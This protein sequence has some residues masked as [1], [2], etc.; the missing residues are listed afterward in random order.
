MGPRRDGQ[1]DFRALRARRGSYGNR[2]RDSGLDGAR[3]QTNNLSVGV[4]G[5]RAETFLPSWSPILHDLIQPVAVDVHIDLNPH[6]QMIR[7]LIRELL[8]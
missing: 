5:A 6:R 3:E 8:R 7:Q 2:K 1:R 4:P